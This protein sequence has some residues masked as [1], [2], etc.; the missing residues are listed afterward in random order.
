MNL[1]ELDPQ[2]F[3]AL[4][5][6]YQSELRAH[7]YRMSGS[8]QDADDMLQETLLRAWRRRDTYEGRASLRAWLYKIA[9]HVCLDHLRKSS[10]RVIPRTRQRVSNAADPIPEA[11]MESIWLTPYP[12]ELLAAGSDT[13]P[14][15]RFSLREKITLA[16]VA[17]LNRLPPRQRAVLLLRDVL[18][19]QASEV[20]ALLDM[21]IPAVKSALHRARSTLASHPDALSGEDAALTASESAQNQLADY[22]RAWENA[23]VDALLQL[24]K[25]DAA[26]S[27]PPIPSWYRGRAEIRA[28]VTRTVFSG[29]AVGRWRLLA[30]RANTQPAFGLYRQSDEAGRYHAYGI[31]VLTFGGALIADITTFRDPALFAYFRLPATLTL[32]QTT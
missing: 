15:A 8:L 7:C 30:T 6:P 14:A 1:T 26:F 11:I 31:Q 17:A 12:D 27:M 16:F 23:D 32:P 9:T 13:D 29:Q 5:E 2:S 18:D 28:L 24:L 22:V 20:A 4:V 21:T 19:C 3:G 10:R 25:E